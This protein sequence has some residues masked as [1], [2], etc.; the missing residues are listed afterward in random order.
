MP[1]IDPVSSYIDKLLTPILINTG[2]TLDIA[3]SICALVIT[4]SF[5]LLWPRI[6]GGN[7]KHITSALFGSIF[8]VFTYGIYQAVV[9]YF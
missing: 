3:K 6:S 7:G 4:F 9:F 2:L 8:L 1:L 5:A